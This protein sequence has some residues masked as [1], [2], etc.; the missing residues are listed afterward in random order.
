MPPGL[1]PTPC[2]DRLGEC[3]A[4]YFRGLEGPAADQTPRSGKPRPTN[5]DNASL[6]RLRPRCR[7][8][9][10]SALPPDRIRCGAAVPRRVCAPSG[11]ARKRHLDSRLPRRSP[12][13][14]AREHGCRLSGSTPSQTAANSRSPSARPTTVVHR[15]QA[16]QAVSAQSSAGDLRPHLHDRTL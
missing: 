2:L 15:G 1:L 14:S 7:C 3:V 4:T 11:R 10:A 13:R 5:R 9:S 8:G 16:I 6:S 12:R